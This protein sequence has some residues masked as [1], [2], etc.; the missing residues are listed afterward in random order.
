MAISSVVQLIEDSLFACLAGW[1][2]LRTIDGAR[3]LKKC[4]LRKEEKAAIL[5]SESFEIVSNM[6]E[7]PS[8]TGSVWNGLTT[9]DAGSREANVGYSSLTE[10]QKRLF[11]PSATPI[12]ATTAGA[13]GLSQTHF[14]NK[15]PLTCTNVEYYGETTPDYW[16]TSS[17]AAAAN[18]L[19]SAANLPS[20]PYSTM[21]EAGAGGYSGVLPNAL[22]SDLTP[23]APVGSNN[24]VKFGPTI[25]PSFLPAAAAFGGLHPTQ[26]GEALGKALAS[27]YSDQLSTGELSSWVAA[28]AGQQILPGTAA[29]TLGYRNL[30]VYPSSLSKQSLEESGSLIDSRISSPS[31][32][33]NGLHGHTPADLNSSNASSDLP[34]GGVSAASAAT[35]GAGSDSL[36]S[37]I[38]ELRAMGA[39]STAGP[40]SSMSSIG[41][42]R[43][44]SVGGGK[45]RNRCVQNETDDTIGGED[46]ERRERDRRSANNARER[47]RVR[48]INEAFKELGRMCS[49]HLNSEKV[50]TKLGILH[51][52]VSVITSLEQQV[53]ER[54][55]NP[56]AAHLKRREEEKLNGSDVK[57]PPHVNVQHMTNAAVP[58]HMDAMRLLSS[59]PVSATGSGFA[60][61]T[62]L[63]S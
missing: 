25:Q 6:S 58:A 51:Q 11:A 28:D 41:Q 48:D 34:S 2:C 8:V 43:S 12:N 57:M 18:V 50:Q 22:V 20:S 53:R 63:T 17:G 26:T 46:K 40:L 49:I 16:L 39:C 52:A 4:N 35:T 29:D 27:I 7:V 55:L 47:I 3:F 1:L 60:E 62:H 13:A 56:K 61:T 33:F 31:N 5:G 54:N 36:Q 45:K 24:L 14:V 59:V 19:N 44:S 9:A 32:V 37:D 42:P 38:N 30:N 23:L 21:I 15:A 10:N